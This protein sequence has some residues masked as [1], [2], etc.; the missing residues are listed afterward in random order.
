MSKH[1][2]LES[3]PFDSAQGDAIIYLFG[4]IIINFSII[5]SRQNSLSLHLNTKHEIF[6]IKVK[7]RQG[8]V[9]D[10]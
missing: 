7:A 2:L 4:I 1:C 3:Q 8:K 5:K 10:E 6:N 9:S